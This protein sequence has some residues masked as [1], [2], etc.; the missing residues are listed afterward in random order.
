LKQWHSASI[1]HKARLRR[2]H[3]VPRCAQRGKRGTWSFNHS[4]WNSWEK[5][6]L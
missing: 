4:S 3:K 2:V 5:S 6:T 1:G